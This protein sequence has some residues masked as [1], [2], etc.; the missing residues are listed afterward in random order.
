MKQVSRSRARTQLSAL[1]GQA[2]AGEDMVITRWS[3]PQAVLVSLDRAPGQPRQAP[4]FGTWE[5]EGYSLSDNF[6][7]PDPELEALFYGEHHEST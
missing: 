6:N 7:D 4:Q 3:K 1:V 2:A 5:A